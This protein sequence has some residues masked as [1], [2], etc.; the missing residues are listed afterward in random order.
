M[1]IYVGMEH[2]TSDYLWDKAPRG[3]LISVVSGHASLILIQATSD[4]LWDKA[5]RA[6]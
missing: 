6:L 4:Y 5:L 2:A 1:H 3:L